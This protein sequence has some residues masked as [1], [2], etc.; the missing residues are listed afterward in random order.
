M[1]APIFHS[2][3]ERGGKS[4]GDVTGRDP[5]LA[6]SP[7]F[8]LVSVE[9]SAAELCVWMTVWEYCSS[10]KTFVPIDCKANWVSSPAKTDVAE[11]SL[12]LSRLRAGS[13]MSLSM[14]S[15]AVRE[16][17][18]LAAR[19]TVST[20]FFVSEVDIVKS[21]C[22]QRVRFLVAEA[23]SKTRYLFVQW[24]APIR[25]A[26]GRVGHIVLAIMNAC[27]RSRGRS[28]PRD[29][30]RRLIPTFRTATHKI[31]VGVS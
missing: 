31:Q 10:M 12:F 5:F 22:L 21:V 1:C 24:L 20:T 9:T 23:E 3:P 27:P 19:A 15:V 2:R 11:V 29:I 6:R 26:G 30:V 14:T 18:G 13:D 17:V 16:S 4:V 28:T 7:R 8:P 25:Q